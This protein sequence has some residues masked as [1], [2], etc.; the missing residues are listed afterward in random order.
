MITITVNKEEI[1]IPEN[2][3]ITHLLKQ[4]EL[5]SQGIAV[6]INESIVTKSAWATTELSAKDEVLIIKA[7]QGG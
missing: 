7:T 5:V 2:S 4:L 1:K 3:S 6:A